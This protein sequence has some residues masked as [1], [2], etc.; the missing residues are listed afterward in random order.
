MLGTWYWTKNRITDNDDDKRKKIET[1]SKSA[2]AEEKSASQPVGCV[3]IQCLAVSRDG[4]KTPKKWAQKPTHSRPAKRACD[5]VC[6]CVCCVCAS[7]NRTPN[8]FCVN[9]C[10]SRVCST[11][12]S[13]FFSHSLLLNICTDFIF[14][15]SC[16]FILSWFAFF[17]AFYECKRHFH[18][19]SKYLWSKLHIIFVIVA[20]NFPSDLRRGDSECVER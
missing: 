11:N 16:V 20:W 13:F 15:L 9:C 12:L 19:K 18:S 1:K 4:S 17:H 2:R 3:K 7:R 8:Y 10:L 14:L 5:A 6:V